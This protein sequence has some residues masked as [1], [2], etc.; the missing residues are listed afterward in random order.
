MQKPAC[1]QFCSKC[2]IDCHNGTI[3]IYD[4]AL[5]EYTSDKE[6]DGHLPCCFICLTRVG[7]ETKVLDK[8]DENWILV[9]KVI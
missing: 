5:K 3:E 8:V 7:D 4:K 1:L 6:W 2:F 9:E